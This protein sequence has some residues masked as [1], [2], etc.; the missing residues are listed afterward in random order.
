MAT[1]QEVGNLINQSYDELQGV[2]AS[3]KNPLDLYN[4]ASASLGIPEV[5]TRVSSLRKSL[6]D[7]E[8]LLAG[9]EGSVTG[10]TSGSLVTEA[11]RQRLVAQERQPIASQYASMGNQLGQETA[12]LTDLMG[13]ASTTTD[14]GIKGQKQKEDSIQTK[15]T[16]YK[17][18]WDRLKKQEDAQAEAAR[19]AESNRIEREKIYASKS[20]S[21]SGKSTSKG[22]AMT[23]QE[24]IQDLAISKNWG[25]GDTASAYEK[26]Y[27]KIKS[28]SDADVYLKYYYGLKENNPGKYLNNAD[29]QRASQLGLGKG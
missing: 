17:E 2:Q 12:G 20:S 16:K 28:G 15:I 25:W 5:R 1:S 4:E 19:V 7:T 8:N 9:V 22:T 6:L 26:K 27:G 14:L 18:E 3:A 10:R 24:M 21:G 13:Q 23:P 29:L 11:Q